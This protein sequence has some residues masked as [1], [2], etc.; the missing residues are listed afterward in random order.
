M[1]L[2][3][4]SARP[5]TEIEVGILIEIDDVGAAAVDRKIA[6]SD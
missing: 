5:I 3:A 1:R 2:R 4:R 6:D